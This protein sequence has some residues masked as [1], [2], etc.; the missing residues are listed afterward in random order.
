MEPIYGGNYLVDRLEE[1]KNA[2]DEYYGMVNLIRK[3]VKPEPDEIHEEPE[4]LELYQLGK[5]LGM[6][7]VSGGIEDQPYIWLLEWSVAKQRSELHEQL[8]LSS[9]SQQP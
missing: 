4:A 7:R 3:Q 1:L 8:F 9:N 5:E 6:P 2:I